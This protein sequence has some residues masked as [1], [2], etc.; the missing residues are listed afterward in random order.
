MLRIL[1]LFPGFDNEKSF[2][3]SLRRFKELEVFRVLSMKRIAEI[4]MLVTSG[5]ILKQSYNVIMI[6]VP[7]M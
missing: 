6:K 7:E 2:Y 4:I 1:C 3:A 5:M